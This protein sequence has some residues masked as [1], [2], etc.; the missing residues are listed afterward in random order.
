MSATRMYHFPKGPVSDEGEMVE[1]ISQHQ[2]RSILSHT[3]WPECKVADG[4]AVRDHLKRGADIFT[5]D[6]L[7]K[8][9]VSEGGAGGTTTVT[10]QE[11]VVGGD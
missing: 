1:A 11:K 3:F 4:K 5:A 10:V 8:T 7:P 9:E 2:A 6:D